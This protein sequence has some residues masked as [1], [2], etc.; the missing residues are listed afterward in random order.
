M[1]VF[2]K[3]P[4]LLASVTGDLLSATE[5][6]SDPVWVQLFV[7]F[8]ENVFI[9]GG[10]IGIFPAFLRPIVKYL[11]PSLYHLPA[12]VRRVRQIV[13]PI[14]QMRLRDMELDDTE[15]PNDMLQWALDASVARDHVDVGEIVHCLLMTGIASIHT[16]SMAFTQAMYGT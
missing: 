3:S 4:L 14:I 8:A 10:L 15:M 13:E 11:I 12:E 7:S 5:L 2:P 16:T 9:G 1:V 6:N